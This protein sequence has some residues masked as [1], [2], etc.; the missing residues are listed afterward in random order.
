V[1]CLVI[2]LL[3]FF[4]QN[5]PVKNFENRSIFDKDMDNTLWLTFLGHPVYTKDFFYILKGANLPLVF[6]LREICSVD[7]E[8]N[9]PPDARF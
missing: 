3:Q 2:T 1:V 4:S 7:S 9:L 8:E 6:K 5:V